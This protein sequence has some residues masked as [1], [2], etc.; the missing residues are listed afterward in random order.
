MTISQQKP[1]RK[2]EALGVRVSPEIKA[3]VERLAVKDDRTLSNFIERLLRNHP[4]IND[5]MKSVALSAPT[6]GQ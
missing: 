6:S 5:E 4:A 1:S 3:A 2:T